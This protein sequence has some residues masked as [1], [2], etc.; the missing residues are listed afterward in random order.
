LLSMHSP[1]EVGSKADLY[2]TYKAFRSFLES[3]P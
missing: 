1:F 3:A 2:M